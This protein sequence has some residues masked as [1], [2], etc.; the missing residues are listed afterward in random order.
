MAQAL[1]PPLKDVNLASVQARWAKAPMKAN[2]GGNPIVVF[3]PPRPGCQPAD[4]AQG[5]SGSITLP[6]V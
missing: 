2:R 6:D 3:L 4:E 5:V 1:A